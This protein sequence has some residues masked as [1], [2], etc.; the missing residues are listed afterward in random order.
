MKLS[1]AFPFYIELISV[2]SF[3]TDKTKQ[4]WLVILSYKN[5][6]AQFKYIIST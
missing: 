4:N 1:L 3:K 2:N 6:I 5:G